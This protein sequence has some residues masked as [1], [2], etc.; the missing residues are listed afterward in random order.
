MTMDFILVSDGGD[1]RLVLG[2][3]TGEADRA[4]ELLATACERL[5]LNPATTTLI[6]AIRPQPSLKELERLQRLYRRMLAAD[7]VDDEDVPLFIG[8]YQRL[9]AAGVPLDPAQVVAIERWMA[10]QEYDRERDDNDQDT[11]EDHGQ[12]FEARNKAQ[13]RLLAKREA[14]IDRRVRVA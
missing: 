5:E 2:T 7:D 6:P 1:V 13:D 11:Q 14:D 4:A 8:V 12:R 10:A 9:R 3:L